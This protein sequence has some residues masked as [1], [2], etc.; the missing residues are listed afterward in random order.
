MWEHRALCNNTN[1]T[2]SLSH[3]HTHRTDVLHIY[4]LIT[5]N[6]CGSKLYIQPTIDHLL[7]V[8]Q[9]PY[10]GPLLMRN[11]GEVSGEKNKPVM[12]MGH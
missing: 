9:E 7:A 12:K 2:H 10:K 4:V 8:Q 1:N 3:T 11:M 6:T 5:A